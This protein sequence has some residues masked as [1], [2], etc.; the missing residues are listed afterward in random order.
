VYRDGVLP[1]GM[2]RIVRDLIT[3]SDLF[4][5]NKKAQTD[6]GN[7]PVWAFLPNIGAGSIGSGCRVYSELSQR[8]EIAFG[9][10]LT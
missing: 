2:V 6:S 10:I 8:S 9:A 7:E 4:Q 5:A 3:R 1:G